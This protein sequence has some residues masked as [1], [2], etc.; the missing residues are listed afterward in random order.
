MYQRSIEDYYSFMHQNRFYSVKGYSWL[1]DYLASYVATCIL[2]ISKTSPP[3][4]SYNNSITYLCAFHVVII[5]V[6]TLTKF[7]VIVNFDNDGVANSPLAL[8]NT[9]LPANGKRVHMSLEVICWKHCV[10]TCMWHKSHHSLLL[11]N[12][13]LK[14]CIPHSHT[15]LLSALSQSP[16]M[17]YCPTPAAMCRN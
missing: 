13:T 3:Q 5:L 14:H 10:L 16:V 2:S 11:E 4:W 17:Q 7:F 6:L 8:E 9:K 12:I 15:V 1:V